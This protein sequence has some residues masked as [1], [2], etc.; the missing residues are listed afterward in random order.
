VIVT[1]KILL[2]RCISTGDCTSYV[3]CFNGVQLG[4]ILRCNPV[5]GQITY[6]NYIQG[7]CEP[8]ADDC[9]PGG[10]SITCYENR[11]PRYKMFL[12]HPCNM[13]KSKVFIRVE[14][15]YLSFKI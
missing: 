5:N 8:N 3:Q 10:Y 7:A 12:P 11:D 13:N 2:V 4:E 1:I 6:Y 9:Y 14:F 15:E